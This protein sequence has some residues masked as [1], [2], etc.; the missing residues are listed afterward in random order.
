MQFGRRTEASAS[1]AP[2]PTRQSANRSAL[3]L[4]SEY[5]Q[6]NCAILGVHPKNWEQIGNRV[7][8]NYQR[9]SVKQI[10]QRARKSL[11]SKDGPIQSWAH[12]PKVVSSNLTPATNSKSCFRIVLRNECRANW[13]LRFIAQFAQLKSQASSLAPV[14]PIGLVVL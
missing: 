2:P 10:E 5:V 4:G 6:K 3:R 11:R 14:L 8:T 7:G 1:R 9:T 12:N 13:K